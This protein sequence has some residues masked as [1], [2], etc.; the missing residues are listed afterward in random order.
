MTVLGSS[1]AFGLGRAWSDDKAG[2]MPSPEEMEK[3]MAEMAA[4][5]E[6]HK[7][8]AATA[9]NWDGEVTMWMDPANPTKSKGTSTRKVIGNG[10]YVVEEFKGE[11]MG[12]PF[13]GFGVHGY[14]KDKKQYVG[15]WCDNVSTTP[16]F[17]WGT[18]D[19]SGKV[20]TYEGAEMTCAMGPYT[21]RWVVKYEDAD[22]ST[23]EHWSKSAMSGGE[24]VKEVEVKS[25]RKK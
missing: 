12:K 3:M 9:G 23:F 19:A 1:L 5:V 18:P 25:T 24:F 13:E 8:L 6:Q 10:L 17:M 2:K 20:V 22:H 21:P 7:T 11:F 16:E 15:F 14:S 4:P